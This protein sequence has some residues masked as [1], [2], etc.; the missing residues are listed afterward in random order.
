MEETIFFALYQTSESRHDRMQ[1]L[2]K[3]KTLNELFLW[4]EENR[5]KVEE[6]TG[7][8]AVVMDCKMLTNSTDKQ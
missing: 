4:V 6:K 2:G 3:A 1:Y 5:K 7:K 8:T